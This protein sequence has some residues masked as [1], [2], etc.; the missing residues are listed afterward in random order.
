M[1]QPSAAYM[2]DYKAK[3]KAKLAAQQAARDAKKR[4][5]RQSDPEARAAYKLKRRQEYLK[6][7]PEAKTRESIT[8]ATKLAKQAR[9]RVKIDSVDN[10]V[11]MR[12]C[13]KC[14]I[15]REM[16]SFPRQGTYGRKKVCKDCSGVS[17]SHK[18][19]PEKELPSFKVVKEHRPAVFIHHGQDWKA[20]FLAEGWRC[21]GPGIGDDVESITVFMRGFII[22]Y[23]RGQKGSYA[24]GKTSYAVL[25]DDKQPRI[26]TLAKAETRA[27]KLYGEAM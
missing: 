8:E 16:E 26:V 20:K 1:S 13:D 17:V 3:N 2:A 25:F 19:K 14:G 15:T 4:K 5:S 27:S 22:M 24:T 12:T 18:K 21:L 7:H 10:G 11:H 6:T 9:T 23:T